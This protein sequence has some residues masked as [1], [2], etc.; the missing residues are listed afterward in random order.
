[1]D[2][3]FLERHWGKLLTGVLVLLVGSC[4]YNGSIGAYNSMVS[5]DQAV[6]E[7]MG[8]VSAQYQRR[9]NLVP[10]LV[11][12]V[13]AAGNMEKDIL[14]S[15]MKARAS[16]TQITVNPK[17]LTPAKL[18]QMQEAQGQLSA[19]L[20]RLM[21][22]SERYPD[23]KSNQNYRDLMAELSGTENRISVGVQRYNQAVRRHNENIL[24]FPHNVV[25]LMAHYQ[26]YTPFKEK[27]GADVAPVVN[28]GGNKQ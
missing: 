10:N 3:N 6:Q 11:N 22:V 7:S 26:T 1:M 18:Q 20:G 21:V 12:T 19:A 5:T 24:T 17:D 15:V 13:A 9:A 4:A 2:K 25:N 14:E 28:F 27:E 16:A 8:N 23:L